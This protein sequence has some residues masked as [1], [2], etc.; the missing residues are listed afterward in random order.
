MSVYL[1]NKK[2]IELLQYPEDAWTYLTGQPDGGEAGIKDYFKAVP[3]LFRGI[4][5]RADAVS[6]MPFS[7]YRGENEIDTSVNYENVVEFLPNPKRTLKLLEMSLALMGVGYL[8]NVRNNV[9]TLDLKYLNPNT[10]TPI[11]DEREGL[12]GFKRTLAK[13][14]EYEVEDIV[15]FWL[16]DPYIELGEPNTS[17]AKAALMASGV[18][19][20]VDEFVAAFFKRGAI[21]ATIFSAKGMGQS[22]A[23]SFETWWN[24]FITGVA[25]SFKTKVL[26][27]EAME[28]T[29]VGDGIDGLQDSELT[30]EK[31][32]DIATAL[33]IPH[34]ILFSNA[35]NYATAKQ[36]DRHFYDKTIVPESKFIQYAL[37][38]QVFKPLDLRLEFHPETLD[39]FQDINYI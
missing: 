32:E 33:G 37:N 36:D 23:K 12:A 17:P 3:W 19:A 10:I 18:L 13:T 31:R 29:V 8:F 20:N 11:I 28:P 24:K 7:I 2:S 25:N 30:K 5:L 26:N 6:T 14:T 27:A 4:G 1:D 16:E 22:D 15:Y 9:V 35:A 34:S 38:E 21:K 39:V